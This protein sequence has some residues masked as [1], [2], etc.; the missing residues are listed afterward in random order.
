MSRH[1]PWQWAEFWRIFLW[2]PI[3]KL[4]QLWQTRAWESFTAL[5]SQVYYNFFWKSWEQSSTFGGAKSSS[6]S[7]SLLTLA[8]F[9]WD[10]DWTGATNNL[11][12]KVPSRFVQ[13]NLVLDAHS[14]KYYC[15]YKLFT[16]VNCQV[17]WRNEDL[18]TVTGCM[19]ASW[20]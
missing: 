20:L 17:A 14:L 3:P 19:H 15:M 4:L 2:I 8:V 10:Y 1:L 5:V 9:H 11:P 16:K 12:R 6:V 13:S 7:K 18:I